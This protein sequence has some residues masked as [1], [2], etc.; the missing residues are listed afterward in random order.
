MKLLATTA[1]VVAGAIGGSGCS[2]VPDAVNPVEWYRGA[3]DAV[4]GV[5]GGDEPEA[6]KTAGDPGS[7]ADTS[8]PNLATVPPRPTPSTTAEQREALKQGLVADRANARYTEPPAGSGPTRSGSSGG[9]P[10]PAPRR[11]QPQTA[12][13]AAP[14][15]PEPQPQSTAPRRA[16]EQQAALPAPPAAAAAP[17]V[18]SPVAASPVA[19]TPAGAAPDPAPMRGRTAPASGSGL[20]PS[21]PVPETPGLSPSTTGRVGGD[22]IHRAAATQNQTALPSHVSTAGAGTAGTGTAGRAPASAGSGLAERTVLDSAG[23]GTGPAVPRQQPQSAPPAEARR[24]AAAP[25]APPPPAEPRA[26]EQSVI[27]NEDALG[28]IPTVP[29]AAPGIGGRRY[30]AATIYFGHGSASLTAA[31][32]QEIARIAKASAAHGA[33]IQVIGHASQRT[34]EL[35]LRDHETVNL[36]MSM[37]RAKAV[38][39]VVVHSG[40]PSDRVIVEARSDEQPEF[41]EVMPSGE[42]ANRRAE[43]VVIY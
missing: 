10:P 24:P 29:R 2:S 4:G 17:A 22:E 38:A 39:D 37:R 43:I 19:T 9:S 21:R 11:S 8:Y 31:E 16:P 3:S 30:L 14:P 28:P 23:P 41:Y 36:E 6:G 34:A 12:P 25:S 35:S 1:L 5:F 26:S 13:Q 20:W 42:A 15:T 7:S 32:R 18:T 33:A 40:M 27:V